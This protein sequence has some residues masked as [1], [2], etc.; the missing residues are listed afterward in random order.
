M[1]TIVTAVAKKRVNPRKS[2]NPTVKPPPTM[3][4]PKRIA[5]PKK[6]KQSQRK[7]KRNLN[8]PSVILALIAPL[9][10]PN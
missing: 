9:I 2:Q 7:S 5:K 8:L 3:I 1:K 4:V 6:W 10:W